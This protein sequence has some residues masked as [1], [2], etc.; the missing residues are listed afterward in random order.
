MAIIKGAGL[1]MKAIIEVREQFWN[2]KLECWL[3]ILIEAD[4]IKFFMES[5]QF[6][7]VRKV[8]LNLYSDIS[9]KR[10]AETIL[11]NKLR[12]SSS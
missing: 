12:A 8:I 1:V 9:F 3:A 10:V 5:M 6:F 4:K 2:F 7:C 11:N